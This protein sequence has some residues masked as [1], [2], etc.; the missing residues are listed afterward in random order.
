MKRRPLIVMYFTGGDQYRQCTMKKTVLGK[1][2]EGFDLKSLIQL[3]GHVFGNTP[4]GVRRCI[5][6]LINA[7]ALHGFNEHFIKR[8]CHNILRLAATN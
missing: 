5:K 6:H 2:T 8:I 4:K 3:L 1:L 7:F